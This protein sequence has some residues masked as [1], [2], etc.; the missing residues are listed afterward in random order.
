PLIGPGAPNM[1]SPLDYLAYAEDLPQTRVTKGPLEPV[2]PRPVWTGFYAGLNA[3]VGF[4]GDNYIY[5][6]TIPIGPGFDPGLAFLGPENFG[7]SNAAFIGG[8]QV[9]YNY[10]FAPRALAGFETDIQGVVGGSGATSNFS[11]ATSAAFPGNFLL[12]TLG[13]SQKLDFIGTARGRLGYL[14]TPRGLVY[15]TGGL[16]YGQTTLSTSS[17]IL[18]ATP[19]GAVVSVSGG[20]GFVS[21]LRVGWTAGG[22]FEWMFTPNWSAKAEY[23]YYDLGSYSATTPQITIAAPSA[24]T[25]SAA[26]CYHGHANGQ[27]VRAG[28]NYHFNFGEEAP[29]I[30]GY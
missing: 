10:H 7:N 14:V 18:N 28:L 25:S 24:V 3:G 27:I 5:P 4:G 12:G 1:K 6:S 20:S 29:V 22:G 26:N 19:A 2:A 15:A 13:A 30:A 9:G 11:G 17:E 8:G 16:A 21:D 23:L